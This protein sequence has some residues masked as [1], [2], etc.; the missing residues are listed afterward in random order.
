MMY[1]NE[2][3]LENWTDQLLHVWVQTEEE[4]S[5]I[6][7]VLRDDTFLVSYKF[8]LNAQNLLYPFSHK[9]D[10]IIVIYAWMF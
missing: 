7:E 3:N 1:S 5:I 2:Q 4:E 8:Y 6:K 9:I 10:L